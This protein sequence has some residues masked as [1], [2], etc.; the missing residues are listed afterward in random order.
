MDGEEDCPDPGDGPHDLAR[1]VETIQL[2]HAHVEHGHVGPERPGLLDR[3][4]TV[5]GLA[6]HLELF[7]FQQ[8]PQA[9]THDLMVVGEQDPQ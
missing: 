2:G 5:G 3:V 4:V 1:G 8:R 9:L 6:D 7:A